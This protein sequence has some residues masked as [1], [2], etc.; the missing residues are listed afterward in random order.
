MKCIV[1][2]LVASALVGCATS[3]MP[4]TASTEDSPAG[5]LAGGLA[6]GL[7]EYAISG[8]DAGT[9]AGILAGEMA[10]YAAQRTGLA[11]RAVEIVAPQFAN[12]Q[13]TP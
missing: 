10:G 11:D 9:L 6:G 1:F 5:E 4:L 3:S 2:P 12:T 8:G 13:Y 7:L